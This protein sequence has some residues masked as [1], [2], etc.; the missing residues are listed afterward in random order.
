M[1]CH[2]ALV[3]EVL[4]VLKLLCFR[5]ELWWGRLI[6]SDLSSLPTTKRPS[7]EHQ[8]V[9]HAFIHTHQYRYH[10]I[11]KLLRLDT[12]KLQQQVYGGT[13]HNSAEASQ[14]GLESDHQF[15]LPIAVRLL[16]SCRKLTPTVP[17]NRRI[18]QDQGQHDLGINQ[19]PAVTSAPSNAKEAF[20]GAKRFARRV[21]GI[22]W[23]R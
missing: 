4:W 22:D 18:W 23:V 19:P 12:I 16:Q 3:P 9:S 17:M 8:A 5:P 15:V 13:V 20:D 2:A 14:I 21:P 6:F 10:P 1:V 7:R 11:P